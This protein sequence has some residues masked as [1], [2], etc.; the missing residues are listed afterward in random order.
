MTGP[1]LFLKQPFRWIMI[2]VLSISGISHSYAQVNDKK[3]FGV[4]DFIEQVKGFHPVAKQAGILVTMA[5]AELLSA[6]GNFDPV[7]EID[8]SRKTFD[9]KHYYNYTNPEV[10]IPLP[11]GDLKTGFENNG[12]DYLS[13]E[14]S[15]GKSSYLGI[16]LPLARGL[17]TDKRRTFLRQAR[18]YQE[19]SEQER[20]QML[21]NLLFEAYTSYWQWAG[22]YELS[23]VY[24]G[25]LEVAK[26]RL[27]LVRV[28]FQNGDRSVM[29]TIEAFTQV[30]QYQQSMAEAQIKLTNASWELSNFLWQEGNVPRQLPESYRPDTLS[31]VA[32]SELLTK[33]E[34]IERSSLYNPMLLSYTYKL[35]ILELDRKLKSQN[36]LPYFSVKTNLLYK[37]YDLLKSIDPV[38]VQN[39]Y[40]WGLALKLPLFL[41]EERGNY[42]KA[43]L[44]LKE[45]ELAFLLKKQETNNKIAAYSNE[46]RQ[47]ASQLITARNL[48]QNYT[49]LLRNEELKLS[50]GESSLFLV[51]SR[52][53]KLV[54]SM[55]KQIELTIKYQK[56]RYATEWAA[57]QLK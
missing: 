10:I 37:E 29:D 53:I 45:T 6:K 40:K 47:L 26:K 41:R 25:F 48:Y 27:H 4:K 30:Q 31:T 49:L 50:Q 52:E 9:G 21:N 34:L 55:Q 57:G 1:H 36:L 39:N 56:A 38:Y 43:K 32:L 11:V 3:I 42:Q 17:V 5:E 2:F 14:T 54:E 20:L 51:N 35:K 12:G 46:C 23:K 28:A 33:E 19:Q 7:L 22:N 24:A 16:E 44:K 8:A 18:I 13:S 15:K